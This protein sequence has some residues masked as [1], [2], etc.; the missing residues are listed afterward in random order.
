MVSSRLDMQRGAGKFAIFL[1]GVY[2]LVIFGLVVSTTTGYSIP[3]LGW[4]I[5]LLPGAAFV[6]SF[7]DAVKLHR[8]ADEVQAARLWR[9][10]LLYAVAGT[11]LLIAA[12]VIINGITPV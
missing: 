6:V 10:S 5:M 3:L 11:A 9:R 12:V 7:L 2:L 4:P 1:T 8:T